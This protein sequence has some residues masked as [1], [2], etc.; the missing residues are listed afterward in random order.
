MNIESFSE[1]QKNILNEAGFDKYGT[2]AKGSYQT[3]FIHRIK[4]YIL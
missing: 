4:C 3:G 1:A 2:T